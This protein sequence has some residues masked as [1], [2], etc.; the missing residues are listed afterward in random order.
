MYSASRMNSVHSFMRPIV[1]A[2][3]V[4]IKRGE[5]RRVLPYGMLTVRQLVAVNAKDSRSV[6]IATVLTAQNALARIAT[7]ELGCKVAEIA[8][9]I[10]N[11]PSIP[12]WSANPVKNHEGRSLTTKGAHLRSLTA[13]RA[14]QDPHTIMVATF[15]RTE[16]QPSRPQLWQP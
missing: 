8:S 12:G 11:Y 1:A 16:A 5:L 3:A 13:L 15:S 4:G 7:A 9:H 2:R 10:F 14:P 6:Q